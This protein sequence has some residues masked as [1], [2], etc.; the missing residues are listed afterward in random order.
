M[1]NSVSNVSQVS[2][3]QIQQQ[4]ATQ[5][6]QQQKTQQPQDSVVLS[7]QATGQVDADHDGDSK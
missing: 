5:V 3:Y 6:K 2:Q 7:K 4:H 1:I